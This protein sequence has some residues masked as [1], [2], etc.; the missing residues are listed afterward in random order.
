MPWN[1]QAFEWNVDALG[2]LRKQRRGLLIQ[3]DLLALAAVAV[4]R[5]VD[6]QELGVV[7]GQAGLPQKFAGALPAVFCEGRPPQ[8]LVILAALCPEQIPF[9]PT[10]DFLT[11]RRDIPGRNAVAGEPDSVGA[12]DPI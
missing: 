11:R 1:A 3:R 9:V 12:P 5:I 8:R 7:I 4:H 10:G 6:P 2:R